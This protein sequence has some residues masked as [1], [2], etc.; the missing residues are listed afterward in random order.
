MS[1]T[2]HGIRKEV[3]ERLQEIQY[4]ATKAID[5]IYNQDIKL[6]QVQEHL[7]SISFMADQLAKAQFKD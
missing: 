6:W 3:I 7:D 4:K 5:A 2:D 1:Q